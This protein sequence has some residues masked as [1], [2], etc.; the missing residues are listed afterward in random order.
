MGQYGDS[1]SPLDKCII[2]LGMAHE[3]RAVGPI[4]E[5]VRLL[6]PQSDF[7]HHRAVSMALE[8]LGDKSAAGALA[9]LLGR[10]GM[11][12]HA[13]HEPVAGQGRSEPLRELMLAGALYRLGDRDGLARKVLES[14]VSD[15]RGHYARYAAAIL[16][17]KK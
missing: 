3:P 1:L 7:S 11:T 5:K 14:Y 4:V 10:P 2:A 17:E 15:V 9:E 6:T 12:G 13:V 8:M 16:A